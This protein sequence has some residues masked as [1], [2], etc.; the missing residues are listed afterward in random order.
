MIV[1]GF[2]YA[3]WIWYFSAR[4]SINCKN[5]N[6]NHKA[7][8]VTQILVTLRK[9]NKN[10]VKNIVH[11]IGWRKTYVLPFFNIEENKMKI[12]QCKCPNLK[13]WNF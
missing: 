13:Q 5:Q 6:N 8:Q 7:N 9:Y 3:R 2:Q 4:N 10:L 11:V 12:K 1:S